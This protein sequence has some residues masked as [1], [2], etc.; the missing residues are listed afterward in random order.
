MSVNDSIIS[1]ASPSD[2]SRAGRNPLATIASLIDTEE[3]NRDEKKRSTSAP[4]IA[5]DLAKPS[6]DH[7]TPRTATP[8]AM[9]RAMTNTMSMNRSESTNIRTSSFDART[10]FAYTPTLRIVHSRVPIEDLRDATR[11]QNKRMLEITS[12]ASIGHG[13]IAPDTREKHE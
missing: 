5:I 12:N 9:S 6:C 13:V 11:K 2:A 7:C 4:T 10:A 8:S 1:D 3:E